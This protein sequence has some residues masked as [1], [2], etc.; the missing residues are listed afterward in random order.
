MT[1]ASSL[2]RIL[3]RVTSEKSADLSTF[4]R[5]EFYKEVYYKELERRNS[6]MNEVVLQGTVLIALIS[7]IFFLL[8]EFQTN[9]PFSKPFF[10]FAVLTDLILITFT[11][12]HLFDSYYKFKKSGRSNAFLP[13]LKAIDKYYNDCA[14]RSNQPAFEN[15]LKNLFI[16]LSDTQFDNNND[17]SRSLTKASK[18]M[19]V[20]FAG[21]AVVVFI[22]FLNF[23]ID[24]YYR[25][26]Q[27][28]K[29]NERSTRTAKAGR[30]YATAGKGT[31]TTRT[32]DSYRKKRE[33]GRTP[34]VDKSKLDRQGKPP[35][36]LR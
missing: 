4:N 33:L 10:Q 36:P 14:A 28:D 17:K 34:N 32:S 23:A 8:K 6:L 19:T 15:H 21:A 24:P 29:T 11:G 20:S 22:F 35:K 18:W 16:Q 26:Y 2:K 1:V 13:H 5:V 3:S 9:I 7:G 12:Y 27:T 25:K 30:T 31:D